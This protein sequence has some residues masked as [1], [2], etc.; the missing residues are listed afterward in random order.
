[1]GKFL[2]LFQIH[3]EY[4]SEKDDLIRPNVS[5][6]EDQPVVVHYNPWV[7]NKIIAK[8]N[9][10]S[11]SNPTSIGYSGYTVGFSSIEVDGSELA[12]VV[13]KYTFSTTGEHTVKYTLTDPTSV[14]QNSFRNCTNL[15]SVQIPNTVTS[16][17]VQAFQSC[18]NLISVTM[19]N[20]I[21][22]ISRNCFYECGNLTDINIPKNITI[23]DNYAFYAC[24]S[25]TNISIPNAVTTI[26]N[27][28]F[29]NCNNLTGITIPNTV[30][31]IGQQ[32][33]YGCSSLTS[34]NIPNGV[35][36]IAVQAFQGCSGIINITIGNGLT[37]IAR[38]AF[39]GCT[40]LTT[41]NFPSSLT[42][43]DNVAFQNCTNLTTIISNAT[44]APTISNNTF[45]SVKN[46]GTLY[47]PIGSTG[48]DVWMG[49]SNY[50]L[51]KYGWTKVEQ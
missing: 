31:S 14:L 49:T 10:T 44:T 43:I 21:T 20:K 23:I 33:F 45:Q 46:G 18:S 15:T 32:A 50:Y 16:I 41:I 39:L 22:G 8:F 35:T 36:S 47:V 6:C 9:V 2:K 26:G 40:N 7:E 1:M 24:T 13:D 5:Y 17:G 25:L 11:T 4:E 37:S 42:S 38:N 27:S 48:Y 51:G 19:S 30:T 12:N 29:Q 3:S 34:M 28:A